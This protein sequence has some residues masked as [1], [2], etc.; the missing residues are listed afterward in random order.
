MSF[1]FILIRKKINNLF[2]WANEKAINKI[3]NFTSFIISD[4]L[5]YLPFSFLFIT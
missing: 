2:F 3:E 1:L 4:L 5:V